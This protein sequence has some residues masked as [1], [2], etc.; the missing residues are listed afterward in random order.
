MA[1]CFQCSISV[2]L[3]CFLVVTGLPAAEVKTDLSGFVPIFDG[4]TLNGWHKLTE[5]GAWK[6]ID[7]AIIGDQYPEGHGGLLV[8][9]KYYSDYE[10]YAEVKCTYPLDTG[11]FLRIPSTNEHFQVTIDFRPTGDIGAIY[12]PFPNGGGFF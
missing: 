7:K 5:G 2:F 8:T 4:K 11:I 9:D 10:F 1:R 6:V 3:L 12:G